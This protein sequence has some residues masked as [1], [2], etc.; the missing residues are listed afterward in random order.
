MCSRPLTA[1]GPG[2]RSPPR[3]ARSSCDAAGQDE[4]GP[5]LKVASGVDEQAVPG[6]VSQE[7]LAVLPLP[8]AACAARVE[9][10]LGHRRPSGPLTTARDRPPIT[11]GAAARGAALRRRRLQSDWGYS[12]LEMR[13]VINAGAVELMEES[14]AAGAAPAGAQVVKG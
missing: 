6:R 9:D 7:G 11:K 4:P 10:S 14:A 5:H 12:D 3:S 1:D 13:D 2:S 8:H